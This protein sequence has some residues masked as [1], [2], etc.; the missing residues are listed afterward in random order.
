MSN[1]CINCF[2]RDVCYKYRLNYV[3]AREGTCTDFMSKSDW[4]KKVVPVGYDYGVP[5]PKGHGRIV[6]VDSI[7]N[8]INNSINAMTNIGIGV[9]GEYLWAKLNDAIDNALIII[10]P[11]KEIDNDKR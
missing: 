2:H 3:G 5:L 10:E 7:M 8:D 6:D 1:S 9:D 11:D 4:V